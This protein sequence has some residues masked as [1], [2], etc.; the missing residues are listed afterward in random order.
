MKN[1]KIKDRVAII[2]VILSQVIVILVSNIFGYFWG[3][4]NDYAQFD[5]P[6]LV[7]A[8]GILM[9]YGFSPVQDH[10]ALE[11]GMIRGLLDSYGDPFSYFIEPVQHE[12]QT[13]QLSGQYGG[14]GSEISKDSEG[15]YYLLPYP[16]SPA[17]KANVPDHAMLLY[18]EE[19]P[20]TEFANLDEI[21]AAIRGEAGTKVKLVLSSPPAYEDQFEVSIKREEVPLPSVE[22]FISKTN[23][24]VGV[25]RI[26]VIAES[27]ADEVSSS[28][29]AL[30]NKGATMF[31]IDLRNNGGGIVDAGINLAEMWLP[32]DQT[33]IQKEEKDKEVETITTKKDGAFVDMPIVL[34]IN[35]NTA[36]AAEIFAGALQA[37]DRCALF[38]KQT[39]GKNTIQL[40]FELQDTS[41]IHITNAIWGL[42]DIPGFSVGHGL[43]PD[44]SYEDIDSNDPIILED[45]IHWILINP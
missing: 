11:Y 40:V 44:F 22:Y 43:I 17:A 32:K 29:E 12:L 24:S 9:K 36:S 18:I 41:S 13:D 19:F 4:H 7:E 33:I 6:I 28:V 38:G 15:K 20:I 21:A 31:I 14:I 16:D 5:F 34:L 10:T 39:Y 23:A 26:N 30:M 1:V 35:E 2:L 25:I 42:P 45:A 37:N 27:T 3:V 8:T